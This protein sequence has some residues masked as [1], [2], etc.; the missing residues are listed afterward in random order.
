MYNSVFGSMLPL[1]RGGQTKR[2][3]FTKFRLIKLSRKLSLIDIGAESWNLCT[4]SS[5]VH[6]SLF[7][8][9]T[10]D[11]SCGKF[12]MKTSTSLLLLVLMVTRW[13]MF[14]S[15]SFLA[16][17]RNFDLLTALLNTRLNLWTDVAVETGPGDRST[18]D[19]MAFIEGL[20]KRF[21]TSPSFLVYFF[22]YIIEDINKQVSSVSWASGH[23]HIRITK[24]V[25]FTS[26]HT[27]HHNN[28]E[29]CA[30]STYLHWYLKFYHKSMLGLKINFVKFIPFF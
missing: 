7:C 28:C 9:M 21:P 12:L 27:N 24:L 1:L 11:I 17:A 2:S 20:A 15:P 18:P 6:M 26:N 5:N 13:P 29:I 19:M 14:I 3:G 16:A 8:R 25:I 30:V 10:S 22:S 23:H 4:Y